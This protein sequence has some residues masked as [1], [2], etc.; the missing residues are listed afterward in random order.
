M[1]CPNCGTVLP[2]GATPEK[3][4]RGRPRLSDEERVQRRRESQA[5]WY[6]AHGHERREKHYAA[7]KAYYQ[8]NREAI[9]ER[10]RVK[11]LEAKAVKK[12][13]EEEAKAAEEAS[14]AVVHYQLAD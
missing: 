2:I 5:K 14:A 12:A 6:A 13:A 9:L 8:R 3:K 7:N 10:L 11:R 1:T 4:P